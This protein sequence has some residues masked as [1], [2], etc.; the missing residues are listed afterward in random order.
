[1]NEFLKII[2]LNIWLRSILL[3]NFGIL[4]KIVWLENLNC[5]YLIFL[6]FLHLFLLLVFQS[7]KNRRTRHGKGKIQGYWRRSRHC[8]RRTHPQRISS[9][10]NPKRLFQFCI[11]SCIMINLKVKKSFHIF[12]LNYFYHFVFSIFWFKKKQSK[13]KSVLL[14]SIS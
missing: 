1:M 2:P 12:F 14:F 8:F 5:K 7:W 13:L 3:S 10:C 11:K 6:F 4:C 9:N